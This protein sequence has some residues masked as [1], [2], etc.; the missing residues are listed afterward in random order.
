MFNEMG[1]AD[2]FCTVTSMRKV[3]GSCACRFTFTPRTAYNRSLNVTCWY[4]ACSVCNDCQLA[5]AFRTSSLNTEDTPIRALV[6]MRSRMLV[7]YQVW[8]GLEPRSV[9]RIFNTAWYR[10]SSFWMKIE[11]PEGSNRKS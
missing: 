8:K 6:P 5:R 2:A 4:L 1:V 9:R 11:D 3:V 7:P 10:R